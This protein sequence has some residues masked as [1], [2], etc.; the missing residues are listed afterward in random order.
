MK[1]VQFNSAINDFLIDGAACDAD[2]A[3]QLAFSCSKLTV[4][5]LEQGAKYVQ[6]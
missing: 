3:I 1:D 5:T 4:E 6:S 2:D